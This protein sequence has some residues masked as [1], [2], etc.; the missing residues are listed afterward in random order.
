MSKNLTRYLVDEVGVRLE[1]IALRTGAAIRTVERWYT[2]GNKPT[3]GYRRQLESW[4]KRLERLAAKKKK[5]KTDGT[6]KE[7]GTDKA[8]V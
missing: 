5:E 3:G 6:E 2:G 4:V 1:L 7:S 8:G